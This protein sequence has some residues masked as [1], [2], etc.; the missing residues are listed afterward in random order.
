MK[1]HSPTPDAGYSPPISIELLLHGERFEVSS[2]GDGQ[3]SLRSARAMKPGRGTVR[4][5]VDSRVTTYQIEMHGGIDP[6]VR[7]QSFQLL[8]A[9]KEAAA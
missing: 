8:S 3:L 9:G 2:L 6:A 7:N 4:V 5:I 1:K